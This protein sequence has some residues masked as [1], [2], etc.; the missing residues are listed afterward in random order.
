MK[1]EGIVK[2][3]VERERKEKGE[4]KGGREGMEGIKRR[5]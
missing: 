5:K 4:R 1:R 3:N 2:E